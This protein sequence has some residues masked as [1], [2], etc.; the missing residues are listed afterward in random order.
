MNTQIL[1]CVLK[2]I[3]ALVSLLFTAVIIPWLNGSA[4]PWLKEKRLYGAVQKAVR[5]AE[6]LADSGVIEKETKKAWVTSV[7]LKMGI[8]VDDVVD[9]FIESAVGELDDKLDEIM[10]NVL[11]PIMY[12]EDMCLCDDDYDDGEMEFCDDCDDSEEDGDGDNG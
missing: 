4:I 9:A 2:I 10:S 11:A 12:G 8:D 5:A 1:D 6:K 7:L 3:L